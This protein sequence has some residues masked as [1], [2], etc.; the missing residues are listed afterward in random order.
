MLFEA[1]KNISQATN[2]HLTTTCNVSEDIELSIAFLSILAI[3]FI[4]FLLTNIL[5]EQDSSSWQV[6]SF[7]M[8]E[9]S[10]DI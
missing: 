10:Q 4:Y 6:S 5:S 3:E 2:A 8:R 9:E 1:Y 7:S